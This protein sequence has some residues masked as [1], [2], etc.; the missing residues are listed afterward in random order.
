MRPRPAWFEQTYGPAP[1]SLALPLS[2]SKSVFLIGLVVPQSL[3]WSLNLN[4]ETIQ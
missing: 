2:L 1:L 3:D 4:R